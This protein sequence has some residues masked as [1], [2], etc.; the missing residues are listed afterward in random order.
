MDEKDNVDTDPTNQDNTQPEQS[1]EDDNSDNAPSEAQPTDDKEE[2]LILGKFKNDEELQNAYKSLESKL[3]NYREVEEKAKAFDRLARQKSTPTPVNRPQLSQFVTDDGSIDVRGYDEA[4]AK[5]ESQ[6][7]Q[8]QA[9]S[10]QRSAQ[11][12]SDAVRAERDYPFIAT[13]TKA[14]KMAYALYQ[15]GEVGSLYEAVKEVAEMR[16]ETSTTAKQAGAKEKERE[17]AKKV[18]SKT[19]GGNASGSTGVIT[20]ENWNILSTEQKKTLVNKWAS[21]QE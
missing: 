8:F 2:E 11:E 6:K 15:S 19:E 4:M 18:R 7:D 5:Y 17:I 21:G 12:S 10:S 1:A 20:Q 9:S 14:Q 3:G 13:D 16:N